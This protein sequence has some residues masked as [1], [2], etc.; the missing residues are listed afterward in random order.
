MTVAIRRKTIKGFITLKGVRAR[1]RKVII[2]TFGIISP[3]GIRTVSFFVLI[4]ANTDT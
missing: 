3:H 1:V 2:I 4:V